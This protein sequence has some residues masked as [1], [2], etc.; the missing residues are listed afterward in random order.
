[1][2]YQ[3]QIPNLPTAIG[4]ARNAVR[5]NYIGAAFV[6]VY[7]EPIEPAL[8]FET[9]N[10]K[11]YK[12]E[13]MPLIDFSNSKK[14]IATEINDGEGEIIEIVTNNAWNISIKGI[15][16]DT[17]K[18]LRPSLKINELVQFFKI[19]ESLKVFSRV[20]DEKE[21]SEILITDISFPARE[22]FF[23]TQEFTINARSVKPL[24]VSLLDE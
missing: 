17:E 16:V 11:S 1:M 4:I 22:A 20:F 14:I 12:F 24:E 21:I 19:N 9:Q 15:L 23:D 3:E 13:L 8:T 7:P 6:E 2:S 18:H 5:T 10:G